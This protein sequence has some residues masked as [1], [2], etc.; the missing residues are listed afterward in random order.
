M[1]KKVKYVWKTRVL[2]DFMYLDEIFDIITLHLLSFGK[3]WDYMN[4]LELFLKIFCP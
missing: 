1:N 2:K 3:F 4:T